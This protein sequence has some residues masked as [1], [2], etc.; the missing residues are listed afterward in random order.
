LHR[1]LAER[2]RGSV[3]QHGECA[4]LRLRWAF[5]L[6]SG[7]T[8]DAELHHWRENDMSTAFDLL[9]YLKKGDLVLRDMGYF[10]L[11]SFH[12]IAAAGAYFITRLPEGTVVTGEKG[13]RIDL[14]RQ[15]RKGG[16]KLHELRV[17][18]G[19]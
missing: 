6:L 14:L 15:L 12:E 8:I 3:N 11:Q 7:E 19:L 17:T 18:V 10:C 13:K 16:R 2:F 4:A 1:S 5:D 9:A